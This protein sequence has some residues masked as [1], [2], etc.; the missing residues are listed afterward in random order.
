MSGAMHF[1]P[2]YL[3][4]ITLFYSCRIKKK[5]SA[6]KAVTVSQN[7][8]IIKQIGMDFYRSFG[9]TPLSRQF[10]CSGHFQSSLEGPQGWKLLSLSGEPVPQFQHCHG[11]KFSLY[12]SGISLVTACVYC[13]FSSH[14]EYPRSI[15]FC[16]ICSLSLGI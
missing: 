9:S 7:Q 3:L 16:P 4:N 2:P 13:L 14:H 1:L 10:C 5:Y 11:D 15:C 8:R 12:L 6:A